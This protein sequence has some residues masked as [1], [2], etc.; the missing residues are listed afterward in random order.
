MKTKRQIRRELQIARETCAGRSDWK[1]F[2]RHGPVRYE[3]V[4]NAKGEWGKEPIQDDAEIAAWKEQ[5]LLVYKEAHF[6]FVTD[7]YVGAGDEYDY[8]N[9]C[10]AKSKQPI[11]NAAGRPRK[12]ESSDI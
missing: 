10:Q 6:E 2:L 1:M 7:P 5:E 11:K 12:K 3:R 8:I 4:K 9:A